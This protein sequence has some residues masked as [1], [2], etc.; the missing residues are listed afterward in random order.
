MDRVKYN[1]ENLKSY[2]VVTVILRFA[3]LG[4]T[5]DW[6]RVD[7]RDLIPVREDIFLF[8]SV[9][10]NSGVYPASYVVVTGRLS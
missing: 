6:L 9:Q 3:Q 7:E 10:T 1:C 5:S 8:H 4:E 2:T